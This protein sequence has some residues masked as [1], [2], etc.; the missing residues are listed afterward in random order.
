MIC[1]QSRDDNQYLDEWVDYNFTIG[2]EHIVIIDHRSEVPIL[3]KWG[4]KVTIIRKDRMD[5]IPYDDLNKVRLEYK[6]RWFAVIAVDQFIVLKKDKSINDLLADYEQ[7]GGLSINWSVFGSSGHIK[8]PEGL[9]KD[10]Y[11]WRMPYDIKN[12]CQDLVQTIA[13]T[14]YCT[15]FYNDHTCASNRDVVMEDFTPCNSAISSSMSKERCKI[16]HY[17]TR[18]H[19]DYLFKIE[20]AKKAGVPGLY[21]LDGL[22]GVDKH[23]TVFDDGLRDF[24]KPKVWEKIEGWFNFNSVYLDMV[25]RFNDAVFVEIGSWKGTSTVCMAD[26]IKNSKK[27]IKFYA[28]DFFEPYIQEDGVLLSTTFEEFLHNIEP[29]KDYIIPIKGD[30]HKVYTQFEDHSIDFLFIDA[31][32]DYEPCKADLNLWYQK[33]KPGGVMAGHDYQ[34]NGVHKAVDEFFAGKFPV[35]RRYFL[36]TSCW[37]VNV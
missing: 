12:T 5:S 25:N 20:R 24:G 26:K 37:F 1:T 30:S 6:S 36:S 14:E 10:N 29:F 18:S 17:T 21:S 28:I 11:L 9:V 33:V 16:N 3:P 34:F 2:F 8:R 23:C 15:N 31:N 27:N 35:D 32:H 4:D 13:N 7:Y 22:E 19:E